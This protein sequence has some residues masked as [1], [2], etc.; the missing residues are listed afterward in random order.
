MRNASKTPDIKLEMQIA[1]LYE[2]AKRYSDMA[3]ALD[4]AE[5]LAK[6]DDDKVR[7]LFHARRHVRARKEVRR[8]GSR[9]P[10]GAR[11]Q[12]RITPAR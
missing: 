10:Q 3:K 1:Q 5:K 7:H 8:I 9:I 2:K 6:T 12:S 4:A 11:D